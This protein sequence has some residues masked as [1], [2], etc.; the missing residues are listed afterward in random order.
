VAEPLRFVVVEGQ[1]LAGGGGEDPTV[2]RLPG[3]MFDQPSQRGF[4][5]PSVPEW[6]DEGKPESFKA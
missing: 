4:I 3:V 2:E 1:P 5:E 6:R